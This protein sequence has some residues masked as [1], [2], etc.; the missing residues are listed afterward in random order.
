MDAVRVP[1]VG[2]DP[3][4]RLHER[5]RAHALAREHV[6]FLVLRLAQ[7]GV[8]ADVVLP[9]EDRAL[10]QQLRGDRERRAGRERELP[11]GAEG[12]IVIGLDEAGGI[13]H[14]F[15]HRL[16]HGIGRQTAVLD[17]QVHRPA[18]AVHP[19]AKLRGRFKLR[20]DQIARARGEDVVMVKA[21]RAAVLHEFAHARQARQAHDV[22]IEVF[23][24]LIE[25]LQPVEQLHILHL[26]QIAGELLVEMMVRVD[27]PRIAEHMARVQYLLRGL[28]QL[29]ADGADHAVLGV[30]VDVFV[31]RI[32]LIAG[33]ELRDVA[34]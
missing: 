20:A 28:F 8:Q 7:V 6:V 4:E 14:N 18:R 12:G 2:P 30:E 1:H 25:R 33:D 24:D 31:D 23:P 32:A 27:Q 34:D 9:G 26:R 17:R 16:H 10:P 3:A 22:G 13:L 5:Q 19:D 11:H 29:R 21:G 15:I